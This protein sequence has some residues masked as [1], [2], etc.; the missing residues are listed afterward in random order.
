MRNEYEIKTVLKKHIDKATDEIS[1]LKDEDFV[2]YWG[3]ETVNLMVEASYAVFVS[4]MEG[5]DNAVEQGFLEQ[6]NNG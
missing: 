2:A 1:D 6:P 4:C 5:Q 3:K